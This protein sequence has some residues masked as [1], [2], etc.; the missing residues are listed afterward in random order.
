M[1]H[2]KKFGCLILALILCVSVLSGCASNQQGAS[3]GS[4]AG[5]MEIKSGDTLG[6]GSTTFTFSVVDAEGKETVLTINTDAQM[7]GE[8]LLEL[9]LIDGE[10]SEYGLY[11]KTVLGTTVDYDQTKEYW[12]FYVDGEYAMTGV[13]STPIQPGSTYQ[14][15]VEK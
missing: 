8:A 12:A 2:L 14:F 7:V 5:T 3:Q 15:R 4:S 11:V 13:D 10:D 1:V 9:G 6:E